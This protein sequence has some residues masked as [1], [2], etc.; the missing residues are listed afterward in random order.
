MN[1][2]S[3][4][5]NAIPTIVSAKPLFDSNGRFEGSVAVIT[6][7]S[8]IKQAEQDKKEIE[9]QLRQSE[10]M[11]SIGQL[12]AGVAHEI[13]NP[14]GFVSSNLNTLSSYIKDYNTLINAYHNLLDQLIQNE[15]I[16]NYTE[17]IEKIQAMEKSMD[18]AFL[19]EDVSSLVQESYEGTDR[20]KKIVQDL[21][22]FAHPGDDRPKYADINKCIESTLNIVWNEIKY[23]A[24]VIKDF[25]VL[26]EIMC[27]PQQL[28]QVFANL[29]INAAQAIEKEGEIKVKT[30]SNNGNIE[31]T[32]SD[33]GTGI[34]KEDISKVFDPFFTTK[35]IGKGTGL[36]LHVA[37][38]IIKKHNGVI[39]V[40]SEVGVGTT[41]YIKLPRNNTEN[42]LNT[43]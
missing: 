16:A 37:Y 29:F 30:S 8:A 15:Q 26:P 39:E 25:S 17:H 36:G 1:Y 34:S 20:I 24:Q 35:D 2:I 32:I 43:N 3:K 31:I 28:N 18:I 40:S 9:S 33:T 22:D 11:A 23:K 4:E 42:G 13:N 14:T 21:K 27:H 19:M 5:G 41:F 38:N 12:A 10:K 7:I 6:D